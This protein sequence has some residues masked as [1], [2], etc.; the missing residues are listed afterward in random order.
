MQEKWI[1]R[2]RDASS[3]FNP[4]QESEHYFPIVHTTASVVFLIIVRVHTNSLQGKKQNKTHYSRIL[5]GK[6][7]ISLSYSTWMM[8][9]ITSKP[10]L[11]I[12]K[13]KNSN[14]QKQSLYTITMLWLLC[15]WPEGRTTQIER[16]Q[17]TIYRLCPACVCCNEIT[18]CTTDL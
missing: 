5:S 12:S 6:I 17:S 8:P 9:I 18:I 16:K 7:R 15:S 10:L 13:A 11:Q 2:F 4:F 1:K 3:F 14:S